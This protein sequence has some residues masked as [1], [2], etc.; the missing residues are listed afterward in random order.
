MQVTGEKKA[1]EGI[2]CHWAFLTFKQF[3]EFQDLRG[4]PYLSTQNWRWLFS[5]CWEFGSGRESSG[6]VFRYYSPQRVLT[7]SVNYF[8]REWDVN[9]FKRWYLRF[10]IFKP[11]LGSFSHHRPVNQLEGKNDPSAVWGDPC[12]H[13]AVQ[14]I[15]Y[16][17]RVIAHFTLSSSC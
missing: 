13:N 7:V 5:T 1:E 9:F 14:E 16:K 12:G 15:N 11:L 6:E 17:Y 2:F 3:Y 10:T 8:S 4:R